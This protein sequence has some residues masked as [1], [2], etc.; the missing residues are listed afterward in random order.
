[1]WGNTGLVQDLR[2]R[3]PGD[4]GDVETM[5]NKVLA[6][7]NN[8]LLR[9]HMGISGKNIVREKFDLRNNVTNLIGSYGLRE[10]FSR[11]G[12]YNCS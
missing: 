2:I 4:R 3:I 7:L 12:Y 9:K 11:R 6:L 8:A 10:S 1:M 5:S